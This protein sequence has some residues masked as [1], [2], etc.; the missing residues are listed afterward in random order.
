M[1]EEHFTRFFPAIFAGFGLCLAGIVN[2]LLLRRGWKIQTVSTLAVISA[3]LAVAA[4]LERP[5]L[6]ADTA[7]IIAI[8]LLPVLLLGNSRVIAGI[9]ALVHVSGR[10]AARFAVLTL[11]GIGI[12]IGSIIVFERADEAAA[13]ATLSEMEFI[14]GAVPFVPSEHV[15]AVTDRGTPIKV[16]EPFEIRDE[17]L[18]NSAESR[19][20]NATELSNHVIQRGYGDDRSNCHGWVFTGGEYLLS[21]RDVDVILKDNEYQ[22]VQHPQ[23]GDVVVYRFEEEVTH[24]AIVRYVTRGEPVLVEGKWGN[25]GVF[26]HAVDKSPYGTEFTYYRTTRPSHILAG[27]TAR[28]KGKTVSQNSE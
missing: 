11:A 22:V 1:A 24:T 3:T 20:L 12:A 4:T 16:G 7:Q 15:S 14:H 28:P 6:V 21:G 27:I 8:G 25:L 9:A 18:V 13:D 26:L 19:Y 23:P 17:S 2:L 10:P 5:A